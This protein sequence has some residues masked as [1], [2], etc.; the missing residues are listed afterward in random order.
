MDKL[1]IVSLTI[2]EFTTEE[3]T[4]IAAALNGRIKADFYKYA[5]L[6]AVRKQEEEK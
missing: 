6:A 4:E 1:K 3:K 2:R 5:I